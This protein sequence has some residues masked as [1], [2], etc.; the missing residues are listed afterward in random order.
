MPIAYFQRICT[1]ATVVSGRDKRG[2]LDRV[3]LS[4]RLGEMTVDERLRFFV[5]QELDSHC[6]DPNCS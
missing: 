3:P 2:R 4:H 6:H 5:Y 1:G